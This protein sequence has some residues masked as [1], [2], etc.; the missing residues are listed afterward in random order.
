MSTVFKKFSKSDISI[1]PFTAHK[2]STFTSGAL[3]IAGGSY[4]SASFPTIA[5]KNG[6]NFEWA[7]TGS[8]DD[9]KNHKKYF[10][11][12]HLFYKNSKLDYG[13]KFS[14]IKYFDNYRVLYDKVNI[15][16]LPYKT[17][18]YKIKPNSFNFTSSS[19][20]LKDDGKGHLYD[21]KFT[22]GDTNFK[23]ENS[24]I[25]YLGPEQ[26]FKKYDLSLDNGKQLVN[27]SSTYSKKGLLDDSFL[28]NELEYI[29]I[30]FTS[31]NLG[32]P[33][34]NVNGNNFPSINFSNS[35]IKSPHNTRYNFNNDDN[36][37]IS[38][39]VSNSNYNPDSDL[40]K[41][42]ISKSTTKTIIPSP[43]LA[44]NT[45]I[46]G[47][48][49]GRE[50]ESEPQ[51]PFEIYYKSSSIHFERFDGNVISSVSSIATS[52]VSNDT[53]MIHILCQ[54]TG[55]LL[56]LYVNGVKQA[57]AT[58]NTI[59]TQNKANIYIGSKSTTSNF[60]TGSLSQI[61]IFED[62]LSQ[63]Q[64]NNLSQSIDN[65]PYVGNVFY[66][67]GLV[68]ITK[69]NYQKYL[70]P[71]IGNQNFT[72]TYKGTHLI[73]EN[74]Y[75]CMA[76]QHE[77][78]VTLNPSARKIKSKDSEDLANFATGSNFKPYVTTIGLYNDNGE[79]L[80]VGKLG[81]AIRMTDEAD[82]TYVVR[83]DT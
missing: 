76:E 70:N 59:Q 26:G 29:N 50:V 38:F 32:I 58:D 3:S 43:N 40:K 5:Y 27:F 23:N 1:T 34:S 51:Y 48:A 71:G 42:L 24:R 81:Q 73:Y 60:F 41:Y 4:Y 64:I 52:S 53:G 44:N 61:M 56:E 80:V 22:L 66:N 45:T 36:F 82:T 21:S 17:I 20:S 18:G 13:T 35:T 78:D 72:L 69:P 14:T 65:K 28:F 11:L 68:A 19:V 55:S 33:G 8:T 62:G 83:F 75:Q 31:K 16:S 74:E 37:A 7:G 57:T 25:F 67:N 49:L 39:F 9:I 47:S 79:L 6:A 54:K 30:T 46:T 63:T 77:F 10:Q 15:L 2:Q 12:N